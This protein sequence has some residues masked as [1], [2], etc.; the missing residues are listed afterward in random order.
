MP[1]PSLEVRLRVL[2]AIDVAPGFSIRSR[3][4]YASQQTFVC[5]NSNHVYRFTWRT[6]STWYY[7]Y[8]KDGI[9]T[10]D[11]KVRADKS[12]QRK[13]PVAQLA[14]AI[15]EVLPTLTVNKV[16]KLPKSSLYRVLIERGYFTRTQLAPTTFYRFVR[17]HD[18]LKSE[19][20]DKLRMAFAMLHANELWQGDTMHGPAIKQ[21]DG[22]WKKTY[23]IAFIDDAS[24]LITHGE[25]FYRDDTAN[26]INAFRHAL[27]KRGKPERL[28]F[29]NGSNYTAK[30]IHQA[31]LRLDIRLSHAPVRDGAAKGKIER[32][33][34]GFRDRFLVL[35]PA[36][37]SL[38]A[39]DQLAQAWIEESYNNTSTAPLG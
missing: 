26:M 10:M 12:Q 35:H 2:A 29:D 14:E 9:T 18:L 5:P 7:R 23:F 27:Y 16:G 30:E 3:I 21:S 20:T 36:F 24:R 4:V 8:K 38:S 28:Y 6:I 25:F 37:D 34:R 22:A 31:C 17:E 19:V 33:F 32:F 11:N 15:N 13:I 39:L 1:N